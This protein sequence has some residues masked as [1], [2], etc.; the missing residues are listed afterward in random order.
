MPHKRSTDEVAAYFS[1]LG[2]LRML[3]GDAALDFA[4]TRHWRD[5]REIDFLTGY[6][7]LIDWAVVAGLL[8][9]HEHDR[10]GE[11]ETLMPLQAADVFSATVRL[12]DI[13]KIH[14]GEAT[15]TT[16]TAP[17]PSEALRHMVATALGPQNLAI[18]GLPADPLAGADMALPLARA[19][20]AIGAFLALPHAGTLRMCEADP[21][22]GVFLDTSRSQKRRWCAMDSCGNRV[23]AQRHRLRLKAEAVE[24][25]K[26]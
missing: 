3:G 7:A 8:S 13:W 20:L 26:R 16:I 9:E 12:R 25:A 10:L 4:N 19:A 2:R 14:L 21:C 18:A 15:R 5:G 1:E 24:P 17:P 6:P 23:K 11:A 22:G